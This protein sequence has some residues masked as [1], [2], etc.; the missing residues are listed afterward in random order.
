M[1]DAFYLAG[2]ALGGLAG[3]LQLTG[4]SP[5]DQEVALLGRKAARKQ[6]QEGL[7]LGLPL[8]TS[9]T[10]STAAGALSGLGGAI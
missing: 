9:N 4:M 3:L 6:R 1:P 2:P 7:L 8:G 5:E 10:T